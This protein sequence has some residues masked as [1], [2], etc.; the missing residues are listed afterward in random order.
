MGDTPRLPR[1][2]AFYEQYLHAQDST[3]LAAQV[4]EHY[5][6]GTLER[7]L[8]HGRREVRRAAA[9][10]LGLVGDYENNRGLGAALHDDDRT[11]RTLAEDGI[12]R[13]WIR[14]GSK[15]D[16]SELACITRLISAQQYAA[17][18][19]RANRL[20]Q[21]RP[22]FAEAWNQR[23]IARCA[24]GRYA[25]AIRDWH[26]VLELNPYQFEAAAHMGRAYLELSN[27]VS[28]LECFR[29]ALRLNPNLEG[30]RA[31]VVRLARMVEGK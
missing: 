5:A 26:E 30:V 14:S 22:A 19:Q 15:T 2:A 9:L 13:L 17:A 10:A 25:E 24:L 3:A 21:Q 12:R 23:G 11:V 6:P 8:S 29:R 7:L 16:R 27:P 18:I 20:V 1:I 31:Q 28:A 4:S